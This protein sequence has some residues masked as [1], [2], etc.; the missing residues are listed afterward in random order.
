[1]PS[2]TLVVDDGEELVGRRPRAGSEREM[3]EKG[4]EIEIEADSPPTDPEAAV[5]NARRQI[6]ASTR[7]T[8][9]AQAAQR[10]AEAAAARA[11]AD[12][13]QA[14]Q[15]RI[16]DRAQTLA[17]NVEAAKAE[18]A[19]AKAALK[20]ARE[21]GDIDAEADAFAAISGAEARAVQNSAL[22]EQL[23]QSA[24]AAP[25]PQQ[26]NQPA[27]QGY[28]PAAQAWIAQRPRF[29]AET[30]YRKVA[31]GAHETA[32]QSGIIEGS[33]AYFRHLDEQLGQVFGADHIN[34]KGGQQQRM[35]NPGQG[36]QTPPAGGARP[37][38]GNGSGGGGGGASEVHTLLG[39]VKVTRRAGG[40]VGLQIP[41]HLRADFEEG[42][43]VAGMTLSNYTMEQVKIAQ[44]RQAGGSGGLVQTEGATY[45]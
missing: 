18:A 25:R 32:L 42:A 22:L 45:R 26:Q 5:E 3:T 24:A 1:M 35:D 16:G 10:D 30:S 11:Q 43:K 2:D 38:G 13:A 14:Q 44:E 40:G 7:A 9:A 33:P 28:S 12:A 36:R 27:R 15:A 20:A 8:E 29:N 19:R 31:E 23:K 6:E 4:P 41:P 21:T 34:P 39:P 17:A 37:S